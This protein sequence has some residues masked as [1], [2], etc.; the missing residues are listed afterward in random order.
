M[1]IGMPLSRP[2]GMMIMMGV[3]RGVLDDLDVVPG[4]KNL[5][6]VGLE[7]RRADDDN[8]TDKIGG[9]IAVEALDLQN[10]ARLLYRPYPTVGAAESLQ[11]MD[12]VGQVNQSFPQRV[13]SDVG[14]QHD[15]R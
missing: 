1:D 12:G 10:V 2:I 9:D 13:Q 14:T 6:Q 3:G 11:T 8:L 7:W 15:P 5:D 4:V